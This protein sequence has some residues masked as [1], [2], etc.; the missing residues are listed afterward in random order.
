MSWVA[1]IFG[2]SQEPA[3]DNPEENQ[4][5]DIIPVDALAQYVGGAYSQQTNWDGDK[6]FG[7]FGITKDYTIVDYRL[8]RLRS[9]QLFTENLY[10]RGIIRRL[11]TNEINKGLALEATPDADIL[12]IERDKM[13][14]WSE[15][16]ERRFAIYGSVRTLIDYKMTLTLGAI[17]RLARQTA[18]VS[19]DVLVILRQNK[20]GLPSV[21]LIDGT[22]VGNPTDTREIEKI[23]RRGNTLKYGVELSKK[24]DHVSFYVTL[25]N[26]TSRRVPAKGVR[27]GRV[28]AW[29]YYGTEKLIDDV[30]GQP[31]LALVI[32]SLKEIDR[33][34]D[35]EQRAAVINSMIALWV[36]KGENKMSTLPMTGGAQRVDTITTQNDSE[37]RKDV[38]FSS[39]M[40]GMMLQELQQGEE[41][42]SYDTSRP[43]VNFG[44]F[45]EAT[46][47]A[48]AWAYEMPPEVMTLGFG[49][50]YS[51]SR[52][53]VNEF[54][55]YLERIRT[56]FGEEFNAPIYQEYVLSEVLLGNIEAPGFLAA[57]RDPKKWLTY[58]SWLLSQWAGAIKPNVDLFKEVRAYKEMID[59][60]LITRDRAARDLTGM[61][62]SKVVQQ[63]KGEN[64]TFVESLQPLIDAGIVKDENPRDIAKGE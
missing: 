63:L 12:G 38:T 45:E 20:A 3:P 4:L 54:K 16:V 64:K 17:Q 36:K 21:E 52:A 34:R 62:Y 57:W 14:E 35:A 10:A 23:M 60:G 53:A 59:E 28:Q 43:N 40:P 46:I 2:G 25:L 50:N 27:T 56:S 22:H 19:G 41:P 15:L 31:L 39:N 49:S 30:R 11:I 7:G 33:Y 6:Y 24:G 42:V 32:Q 51:A 29:L 48:I 58:H 44:V 8:L 47:S 18:L 1:T 61:K 5:T 13:S 55:M 37:G 9:S 26:G